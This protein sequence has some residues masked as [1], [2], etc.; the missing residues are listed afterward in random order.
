MARHLLVLEEVIAILNAVGASN[1][2]IEKFRS[3]AEAVIS[4]KPRTEFDNVTVSSGYGQAS[5]RGFVELTINDTL[6]QMEVAKATEIGLMMLA[7]AEAAI[8]D[9]SVVKLLATLGI[10]DPRAAGT[11]LVDLRELRQGSRAIVHPS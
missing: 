5:Q 4:H 7:A 6:T 3:Q 1:A 2:L 11:I 9:E 10:T 8:S